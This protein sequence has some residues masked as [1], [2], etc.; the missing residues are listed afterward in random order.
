M[1]GEVYRTSWGG[2]MRIGLKPGV[3]AKY[4]GHDWEAAQFDTPLPPDKVFDAI[5][6]V[7]AS[8]PLKRDEL[9]EA[10]SVWNE[11][12]FAKKGDLFGIGGFYAVRGK[13]AALL[14]EFD[15]GEG[16]LIPVPLFMDDLTTPWP[17]PVWFI[18]F[19]AS[20]GCFLPD[21]SKGLWGY[22]KSQKTGEETWRF[23]GS[24]EDDMLAA[25]SAALNGSALWIERALR[26]QI[27]MHGD[28]AKAIWAAKVKPQ[29]HAS[30][31]R[32]VEDER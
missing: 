29:L 2:D 5:H 7:D 1:S 8:I 25:S 21:E 18:N 27:F 17:E 22:L 30:R 19:G 24:A 16:G 10:A 3:R 20:K 11:K 9:P 6:K 31:V 28:L 14:H 13:M 23:N 26:S 12:A 15:L 4:Y 32:I